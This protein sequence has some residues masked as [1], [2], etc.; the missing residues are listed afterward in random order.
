MRA[1]ARK[2]HP[3]VSKLF[4]TPTLERVDGGPFELVFRPLAQHGIHAGAD[5]LGLQF[6]GAVNVPPQLEIDPPDI[7]GLLVEKR[8]RAAVFEGRLEPEPAF[9]REI[10]LHLHVSDQE[11]I[12]E[13]AALKAQTQHLARGRPCAIASDQPVG[14][15]LVGAVGCVDIQHH[16]I[17]PR[18]HPRDPVAPADFNGRAVRLRHTDFIHEVFLEIG[19]LQ[20]DKRRSLMAVF[21]LQVEFEHPF[22]AMKHL[23][24]VPLNALVDHRFARAKA[25]ANLERAF[26]KTDSATALSDTFV[27]IQYHNRR[28]LTPK[29]KRQRHPDGPAPDDHHRVTPGGKILIRSLLVGV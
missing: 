9:G 7:V 29:I 27:I 24:D 11:I 12:L 15:K 19:L 3:A 18:C 22:I 21:G 28:A 8:R 17:D 10:G 4:H 5:I 1:V 20:V 2:E 26:G 23:A 16:V 13:H 6:L 25:V 14:L